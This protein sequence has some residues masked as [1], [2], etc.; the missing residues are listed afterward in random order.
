MSDK[1]RELCPCHDL[2]TCSLHHYHLPDEHCDCTCMDRTMTLRD[3]LEFYADPSCLVPGA[4]WDDEAGGI[5]YPQGDKVVLDTGQIAESTLAAHPLK[6]Y[7]SR[8][9]VDLEKHR[10]ALPVTPEAE[11]P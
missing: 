6:G 3:A 5:T 4:K 1:G 2:N 10:P 7:R 8:Y 9:T 11:T